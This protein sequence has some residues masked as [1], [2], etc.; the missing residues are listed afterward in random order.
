[1][2]PSSTR[3]TGE[4]R[5]KVPRANVQKRLKGVFLRCPEILEGVQAE[6]KVSNVSELGV[7]LDRSAV[8]GVP[9]SVFGARA[10]FDAHLLVGTAA[11]P[12]RIRC[13]HVSDRMIGFEFVKAS[14]TLQSLVRTC[15]EAELLGSGLHWVEGVDNE[16]RDRM[17]N[18]IW[19]TLSEGKVSAFSIQLLGNRIEWREGAALAWEH[20]GRWEP[21]VD[22]L[23]KQLILFVQ[24]AV[25]LEEGVIR[26]IESIFVKGGAA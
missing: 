23:R 11:A 19:Y 7:G 13:I 20:A 12:V 22:S 24:N 17:E 9:M 16:L 5:R 10:E 1:M 18:S 26:Q 3:K 8:R 25:I 15:F 4:S 6:I 2:S 21:L 14:E